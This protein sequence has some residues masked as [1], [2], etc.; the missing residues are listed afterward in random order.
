MNL[1][2]SRLDKID[3]EI[4]K[5]L[6]KDGRKSFTDISQEMG[7][8]VGMIRNR[9]QR[10]V[11]EKILNIVGWTDPVKAGLNSYARVNIKVRPADK[12]MQVAEELADIPEISF[13]ALTSGDFDIEINM[14]CKNNKHFLQVTNEKIRPISGVF[15]T[16]TTI[17][18]DVMKW[19]SQNVT[20]SAEENVA[21]TNGK[22]RRKSKSREKV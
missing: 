9:Y 19:A 7:A 8:S 16:N 14:T 2:D 17:Y 5:H 22:V 21:E 10:L 20:A 11:E 1:T 13:L 18:F 3:I 12:L 4:L 6:Q 15:D